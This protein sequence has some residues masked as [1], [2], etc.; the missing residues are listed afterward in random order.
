MS[1]IPQVQELFSRD[2]SLENDV[3]VPGK[4]FTE[5]DTKRKWLLSDSVHS[6]EEKFALAQAQVVCQFHAKFP[7]GDNFFMLR[8]LANPFIG[9]FQGYDMKGHVI[10]ESAIGDTVLPLGGFIFNSMAIQ[11]FPSFTYQDY[12]VRW[13]KFMDYVAEEVADNEYA[14]AN[15]GI[16]RLAMDDAVRDF[17]GN[18]CIQLRG[19]NVLCNPFSVPS[20]YLN[21]PH[22]K[23]VRANISVGWTDQ[24]LGHVSN[25]VR[26]F[27]LS[28]VPLMALK[29]NIKENI[30][31]AQA[32][33]VQKY[34]KALMPVKTIDPPA[35]SSSRIA[36]SR[37]AGSCQNSAR[38][39]V[40]SAVVDAPTTTPISTGGN[41]E[42]SW[43]L[44]C[45]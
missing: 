44:F 15:S 19:I 12:A 2:D 24:F 3:D 10:V 11:G 14:V 18:I 34:V 37:R 27:L 36:R 31:L 30:R 45:C 4:V 42:P 17:N 38:T 25:V 6:T 13:M 41:I 20:K 28:L 21:A 23:R 5:R 8:R 16:L 9:Q 22:L 35:E 7:G 1:F 40:A 32:K 39:L 26:Q 43:V 33:R 29:E